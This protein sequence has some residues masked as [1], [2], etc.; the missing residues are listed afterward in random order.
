MLVI[1]EAITDN[2]NIIYESVLTFFPCGFGQFIV[3]PYI[4]DTF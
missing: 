4:P 1:L 2:S 3:C